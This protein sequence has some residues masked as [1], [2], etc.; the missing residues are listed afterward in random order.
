MSELNPDQVAIGKAEGVAMQRHELGG[1]RLVTRE[2]EP[3]GRVERDFI[4]DG[5]PAVDARQGLEKRARRH[6]R[7]GDTPK[8]DRRHGR[9]QGRR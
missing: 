1:R 2:G 3:A 6:M 7:L 4:G 9:L 5:S 8:N